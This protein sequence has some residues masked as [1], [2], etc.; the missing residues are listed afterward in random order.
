MNCQDLLIAWLNNA[1]SMEMSIIQALE[2]H[3]EDTI[4]IPEL[5]RK[6][7]DRIELT[8]NQA[9]QV[10]DEIERLGGEIFEVNAAFAHVFGP[11]SDIPMQSIKDK[12]VKNTI[13]EYAMENFEAASYLAIAKAAEICGYDE[14]SD[15]ARQMIKKE[16]TTPFELEE[17]TEMVVRNYID[18]NIDEE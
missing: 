9:D 3:A 1:Y 12:A 13:T 11:L 4:E 7:E 8:Q 15:L 5:R 2:D 10:R 16:M 14:T 6:I 18:K 17:Q